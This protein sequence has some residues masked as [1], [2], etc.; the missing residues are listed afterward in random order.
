[1]AE[2]IPSLLSVPLSEIN[3]VVKVLQQS[4]TTVQIDVM[5]GKFVPEKHFSP[6]FVKNLKTKLKKEAHLMVADPEYWVPKYIDA[7]ADSIIFHLEAAKDPYALIKIVKKQRK[8]AG[9]A[10]N[11]ETPVE[12]V[13]HYLPYLDKVLVMSV[14]PGKGGQQFLISSLAKIRKL[15]KTNKKIDIEVD[16]GITLQNMQKVIRA[17][18]NNLVIGNALVKGDLEKNINLFKKL[19]KAKT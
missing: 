13:Y 9:I 4:F 12:E 7:G 16:G 5:D 19:V 14:H 8:K 17:G 11:P 18:A 15:R 2:I 6:I 10:I 1:M 3:S